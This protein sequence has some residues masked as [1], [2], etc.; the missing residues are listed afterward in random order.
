MTISTTIKT[1]KHGLMISLEMPWNNFCI[2]LVDSSENEIT[3]YGSLENW[4]IL[5]QL[6]KSPQYFY[7]HGQNTASIND[8]VEADAAALEFYTA[9]KAKLEQVAA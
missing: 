4:W 1:D 2:E 7:S 8:V 6:P 5:R 9:E 3:I